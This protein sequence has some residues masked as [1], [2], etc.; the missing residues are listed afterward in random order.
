[1]GS[2]IV[3]VRLD[4]ETQQAM[5]ALCK[6][7]GISMSAA[8]TMFAKT[9]VRERRI[10]FEVTADPFYSAQNL[11]HLRHS[12]AQLDSEGAHPHELIED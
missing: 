1:M 10:P 9:M 7:L 4:S 5:K 12:I 2:A 8:F 11:D 3:N 6:E